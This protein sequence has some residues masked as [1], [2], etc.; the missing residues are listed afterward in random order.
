[1]K[2]NHQTIIHCCTMS[3]QNHRLFLPV[4]FFTALMLLAG[5]NKETD[6]PDIE[7]T[8]NLALDSITTTKKHIVVW[9]EIRVT[10]HATGE[11]LVYKWETNS[12]SM[13]GR[14]S[15]SVRYWGCPSCLGL[16]TIQCI[17]SNEFGSISDTIM[18][19]VDP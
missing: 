3:T 16:N 17:V 8:V 15:I 4:L 14:D 9:E 5:C 13:I 1:M 19:Q 7:P 2:I 10:A 11:N 12:G 18:V 6:K